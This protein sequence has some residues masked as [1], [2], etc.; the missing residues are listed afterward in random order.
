MVKGNKTFVEAEKSCKN[1]GGHL[2]SVHNAFDNM[3]V[4]DY[5]RNFFGVSDSYYIGGNDVSQKNEWQ[6][7]DGTPF[8]F[9]DYETPYTNGDYL[10]CLQVITDHGA[11][12]RV[13]CYSGANYC[14]TIPKSHKEDQES[15]TN[16]QKLC[17]RLG[18]H[19]CS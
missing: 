14:C 9:T 5:A 3:L 2:A 10:D 17:R 18:L 19:L 7:T 15:S 1:L 11:W 16:L 13:D 12:R 8:D 6:W 4:N